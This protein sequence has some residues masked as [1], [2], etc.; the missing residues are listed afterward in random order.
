MAARLAGIGGRLSVDEAY[1]WLVASAPTAHAFTHRL[2]ASEN[3]PPLFYLLVAVM[4]GASPA[5]LRVPAVIPGIALCLVTFAIIRPRLGDRAALLG[6]LIVAADPYLITYAD[7]ARGFMLADLALLVC[8]WMLLRLADEPSPG[9]WAWFVAAGVVAIYTE[10]ASAITL[11]AMVAVALWLGRPQRRATLAAG[12]LAAVAIAPWI[13]QIVRGQDQVGVTKFAPMNATP[14]LS[15]L[16]DIVT[17]LVAGENGG[18]S[19][20][21]GRWLEC[22]VLVAGAAVLGIILRRRLAREGPGQRDAVALMLGTA[23]LSLVAFAAASIVGVHI[24]SQR[25]LTVL[26]PLVAGPIAYALLAGGTRVAAAAA[27]VLVGVGAVEVARR[28]DAQFQTDL[29]PVARTAAALHPRT[30]LT[31]T[32][33]VLYYLRSLRPVMDRPYNIGPGRASGCARPCLIVDDSRVP[34]GTPRAPAPGAP[35]GS[36]PSAIGPFRLTLER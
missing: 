36:P 27:I 5:W 6:A 33:L 26:V 1:T 3:S 12:A 23:A 11:A 14:T 15:G 18:T 2:A 9:R 32:P 19:S 21:G 13:G 17:T 22:L 24:F 30:I 16:R 4:P 10:Y 20:A 31:N 34:G 8:V 29:T 7:L 35:A 25:Y 28:F